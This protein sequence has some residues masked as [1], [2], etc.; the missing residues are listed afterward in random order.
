MPQALPGRARRIYGQLHA[1]RG[2]AH[3][4][5]RPNVGQAV[6]KDGKVFPVELA[7]GE[8]R[9]NGRRIFTGFVRDLSSRQKTEQELRQ[10]QKM[11]AIGQLTGGVAH[12]FNNMLTVI[13]ANLELLAPP[14]ADPRP[15]GAARG[16]ARA[17]RRT[18]PSSRATPR[19]RPAPA[20]QPEADRRRP[21]PGGFAELLR[22]T[23]G[24]TIEL[25]ISIPRTR[26]DAW[27]TARNCGTPCSISPST[28]G[29]PC[30][31]AGN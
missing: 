19:L 17:R 28:P 7:V 9:S 14:L 29:T 2:S 23:L 25:R 31:A 18:A 27:S 8:A 30:R 26:S 21:A 16:S 20:A 15:A 1:H 10:S 13:I 22:R 4:R 12:D 11:E 24:E 5:L 6:T 3:H